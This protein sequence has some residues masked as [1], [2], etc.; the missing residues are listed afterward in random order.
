MQ[1]LESEI[2]KSAGKEKIWFSS[3]IRGLEKDGFLRQDGQTVF[4]A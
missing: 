1:K 4:L 3:I 2:R